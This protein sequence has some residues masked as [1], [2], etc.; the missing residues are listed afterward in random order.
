MAVHR[1]NPTLRSSDR[2]AMKLQQIIL[3]QTLSLQKEILSFK[4]ASLNKPS[5]NHQALQSIE[6]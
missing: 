1:L 3:N 5:R 2:K 6:M 4:G